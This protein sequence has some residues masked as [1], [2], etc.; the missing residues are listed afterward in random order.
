MVDERRR[1]VKENLRGAQ[2]VPLDGREVGARDGRL[3]A[4]QVAR[5]VIERCGAVKE[6]RAIW[7]V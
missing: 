5:A 4:R 2:T 3:G 6:A 7:G 1:G